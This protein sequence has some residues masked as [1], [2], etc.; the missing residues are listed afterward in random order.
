MRSTWKSIDRRCDS[1]P[2]INF[3]FLSRN[4][5]ISCSS[6]DSFF[7][8]SIKFIAHDRSIQ[9]KCCKLFISMVTD[10]VVASVLLWDKFTIWSQFTIMRLGSSC[11][12]ANNE[13]LFLLSC[14]KKQ[15]EQPN[16]LQKNSQ[17]SYMNPDRQVPKKGA[18]NQ[19]RPKVLLVVWPSR[20]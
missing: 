3:E 4:S 14:E 2:A 16:D 11:M 1:I 18:R 19:T 17:T 8:D 9:V 6:L 15:C 12:Q 10:E 7:I 20:E 13:V 5:L